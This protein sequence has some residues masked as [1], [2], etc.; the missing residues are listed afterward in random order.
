MIHGVPLKE[1]KTL[2]GYIYWSNKSSSLWCTLQF[3][4]WSVGFEP[5]IGPVLGVEEFLPCPDA[6]GHP[7]PL[8]VPRQPRDLGFLRVICPG[9]WLRR[10]PPG[11]TTQWAALSAGHGQQSNAG[12]LALSII[13]SAVKCTLLN[14]I[15]TF[16]TTK[17][18][19]LR[20]GI[21]YITRQ[22]AGVEGRSVRLQGKN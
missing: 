2:N 16:K 18:L 10:S 20:W 8:R 13:K 22:G 4:S 19:L 12:E 7:S 9:I 3:S 17:R 11:F 6:G 5:V 15:S 14:V 21:N 1:S